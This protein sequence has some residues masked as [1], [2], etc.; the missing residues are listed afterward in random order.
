MIAGGAAV[1]HAIELRKEE[2][3][4][5]R[6][7]PNDLSQDWEF[8]ILRSTLGAFKHPERLRLALEEEARAGWT[9]V[10]KF[11]NSRVR[12]KRHA[13]ERARDAGREVDPYRTFFGPSDGKIARVILAGVAVFIVVVAILAV[14]LG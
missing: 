11:D 4:M 1:A 5:T 6:Y 2:E 12:L 9:L 3:E 14:V 7:G 13:S 8:K 10:E